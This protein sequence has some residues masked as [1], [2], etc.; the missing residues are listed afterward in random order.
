MNTH[1]QTPLPEMDEA[2]LRC[3]QN[4]IAQSRCYLEYGSGAS[5]LYAL[6]VCHV[7]QVVAVETAP[8]WAQTVKAQQQSPNSELALLFCDVG[9]VRD[10]GRPATHTKITDY[11]RYMALPWQHVRA[12]RWSPDLVLIDGRF[13]VASFLYSLMCARVGTP[14]LFDDYF[15]RPHYFEVERFCRI[16][17]RHGRMALFHA[18]AHYDPVEL[19]TAIAQYAIQFE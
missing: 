5:T 3:F 13:R 16:S 10:Y 19:T 2:G 8:S 9:P 15:N 17:E 1:T 12:Q 11:W 7:P 14:I 18:Q 4:H 6:N